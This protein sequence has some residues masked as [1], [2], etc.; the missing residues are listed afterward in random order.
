MAL[1]AADRQW[2]PARQAQPEFARARMTRALMTITLM[3]AVQ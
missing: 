3:I 2:G 1:I